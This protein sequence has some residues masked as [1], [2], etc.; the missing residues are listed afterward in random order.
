MGSTLGFWIGFAL[1]LVALVV[2]LVSGFRRKRRLHLVTGPLTLVLL[3]VTVVLTEQLMR[4]YTFPEESLRFHLHFAKAGGLCAV[5][6]LLTGLWLWRNPRARLWHRLAVVVF[7][8]A[9]L[10][11]TGTGL[12]LFQQGTAKG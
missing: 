6:V 1:T 2:S 4:N 3:A 8:V 10:L 7:V 11:A 5:P 9:A 12:W